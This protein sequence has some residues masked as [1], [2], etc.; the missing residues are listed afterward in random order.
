M[1]GWNSA[2]RVDFGDVLC[3]DNTAAKQGGCF[4]V[5]GTALMDKD[6]IMRGNTAKNGGCMCEL[7]APIGDVV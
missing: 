5:S 7:G 6:T 1:F 3:R 4:F 2:G